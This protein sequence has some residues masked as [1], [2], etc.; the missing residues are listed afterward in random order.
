MTN[1][2]LRFNKPTCCLIYVS[3]SILDISKALM[4]EFHYTMMKCKY[5]DKI[6]LLYT[7]TDSLICIITP[8]DFYQDMH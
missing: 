3:M 6:R 5:D 1:T 2:K 7:D 4:Y 8:D